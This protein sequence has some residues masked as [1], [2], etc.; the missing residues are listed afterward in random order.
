[1]RKRCGILQRNTR[2]HGAT[3]HR[4]TRICRRRNGV[5]RAVSPTIERTTTV[6][7]TAFVAATT[8]EHEQ[9]KRYTGE[10][11]AHDHQRNLIGLGYV[12]NIDLAYRRFTCATPVD[13]AGSDTWC[14]LHLC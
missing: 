7:V 4:I 6:D 14:E 13:T 11:I 8:C 2:Q 5:G 9:T 3:R 1:M 10:R 12:V